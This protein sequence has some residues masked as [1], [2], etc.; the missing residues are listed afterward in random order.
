MKLLSVARCNAEKAVE[1]QIHENR[2]ICAGYL[3][4]FIATCQVRFTVVNI[5]K[6]TETMIASAT[7]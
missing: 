2:M 6:K 3:D 5:V 7:P 1:T 4:G